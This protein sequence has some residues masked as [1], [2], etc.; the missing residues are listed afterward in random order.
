MA[1]YN[2]IGRLS[3]SLLAQVF[4]SPLGS[5]VYEYSGFSGKELSTRL[6]GLARFMHQIF[7]KH[8]RSLH[9]VD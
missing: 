9:A 8:S 4:I 6:A 1:S 5:H 2:Q 3:K 7:E